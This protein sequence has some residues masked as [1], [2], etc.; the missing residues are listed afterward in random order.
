MNNLLL[1]YI[2]IIPISVIIILVIYRLFN[3]KEEDTI[4]IMIMSILWPLT[5]LIIIFGVFIVACKACVDFIFDV[6]VGK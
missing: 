3:E 1:G 5:L 2:S 4:S 6:I